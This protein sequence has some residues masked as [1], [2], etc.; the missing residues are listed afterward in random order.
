MTAYVSGL[1]TPVM[2]LPLS[3]SRNK[4]QGGL[5]LLRSRRFGPLFAAQF[6][7][8]FNDNALRNALVLMIAYRADAA[9]QFSAQI[10]IPLAAGLFMLP[11]FLCSATAG[12]IADEEDKAWLIRLVKLLEIPVML[13][14]AGGVLAGSAAVLLALLFVMG[15]QAA[16]FG[17][18]KYAILPDLLGPEEL[19]LGNALV[20]A[21]TFIAI[22]LGTIAGM[23]IAT[24]HGAAAI[25][26]LM[27]TIAIAAWAAS[28][29]IPA[30]TPAARRSAARW[31][32]AAAT[33]R[34]LRD[35]AAE[36]VPFRSMLGISWFWLAGATYLSQFP[37]YVR[38]TLAAEE[39]VVTLFLTLFSLGIAAGSL[40]CNRVLR[41]R[42]SARSVP[43][44]ALGLA[45]FS[46]DLWLASPTPAPAAALASLAGFLG[47]P[48]HWRVVADLFGIAASGGIFVVPLYALLQA[49]SERR[50]R[51]RAIAANNIVNAAAMVVSAAATMALIAIGISV[52]ELFLLTG[53]GSLLVAALFWRML[54]RLAVDPKTVKS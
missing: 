27:I 39:T 9:G 6:L 19:L 13:A 34:V 14:A 33:A 30:T 8:A 35:V 24:R 36:P 16:F 11:F 53:A 42:L 37:S 52:P 10:L 51:A 54:P 40:L 50:R 23:L 46:I 41:G 22:L 26:A 29:A 4:P 32:L 17:P 1:A 31:N 21:G 28:C 7:S 5:A 15:I 45:G 25:A 47:E 44:G 38:F 48:A 20:E 12:Q 2:S 18:L 49:A 43:W 3:L